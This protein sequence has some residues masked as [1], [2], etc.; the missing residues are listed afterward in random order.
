MDMIYYGFDF[1][2]LPQK[3]ISGTYRVS[4]IQLCIAGRLV[5]FKGHKWAFE[6]LKGLMSKYP[7]IRLV[8]AGTGDYED[9]LRT[10]AQ[11]LGVSDHVVW[12]GYR[13][14]VSRWMQH[15]DVVLVP[16]RSEGFG[17]V[18]LEA[19]NAQ[20]PVVAFNVPAANELILPGE[21]GVLAT[22]YD[23]DSLAHAIE[24]T[25]THPAERA[26]LVQR[27]YDRLQREFSLATMVDK[28]VGWYKKVL[29]WVK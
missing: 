16:S 22:P 9:T 12:L 2:P 13:Q 5:E 15:S 29:G 20:T 23:P 11:E 28:T 19:F 10:F 14:D 26:I 1:A 17:V 25:L 27:A 18:F 7:D 4:N 6:A 21:T 24:W 3:E 8:V